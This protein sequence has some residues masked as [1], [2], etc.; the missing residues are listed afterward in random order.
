[1]LKITT[2]SCVCINLGTDLTMHFLEKLKKPDAQPKAKATH[3][4]CNKKKKRQSIKKAAVHIGPYIQYPFKT[5][6]FDFGIYMLYNHLISK[7]AKFK[8]GFDIL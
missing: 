7:S 4:K 2:H 6:S 3:S 8:S 1:M 5:R